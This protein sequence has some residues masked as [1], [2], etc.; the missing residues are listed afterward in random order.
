MLVSSNSESVSITGVNG[1][2]V[3]KGTAPGRL[4]YIE[5]NASLALS[6]LAIQN[7][8]YFNGGALVNDGDLTLDGVRVSDNSVRCFG[9]GAQTAFA[10]CYGGAIDN[11]G[12]L[13]LRGGSSF[14]RN[15]V[16]ASASTASNP[17][18]SASGGAIVNSGDLTID[19]DVQFTDNA[20][21][22]SAT[23]GFHNGAPS[24]A[25][26]GATG[27]AIY[28]TRGRL[29]VVAGG[30]NHCAF[31]HNSAQAT[32]STAT[33]SAGWA[34]STGGAITSLAELAIPDG[35]CTFSDNSADVDPDVHQ[36]F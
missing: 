3:V 6:K 26:A 12:S 2:K 35:A 1:Q 14:E 9:T 15:V 8:D 21:D 10:L 11:R 28:H 27:G 17:N 22:A 4:F 36:Q 16:V 34:T 30:V 25:S 33:G 7:F 5:P 32:A 29:A 18:A 19:G 13:K 20:A 23:A 31:R 24:S